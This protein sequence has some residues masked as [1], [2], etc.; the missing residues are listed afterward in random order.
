MSMLHITDGN[1]QSEILDADKLAILDLSAAWCGP[2]KILDPILAELVTEY[3]GRAVIGHCDVG[4]A[5]ETARR[6]GVMAIPTVIYFKHG[7]EVD[8]F[9]GLLGKEDIV[10]KI[11]THL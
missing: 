3:D 9:V 4:E 2:C 8:R 5:P 1:L 7:Q 11:D 6:F 10:K